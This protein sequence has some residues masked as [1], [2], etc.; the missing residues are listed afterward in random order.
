L[1]GAKF[2]SRPEFFF[3]KTGRGILPKK[4]QPHWWWGTFEE[5]TILKFFRRL[6]F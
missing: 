6:F 5:A 3:R 2:L 4:Q 1:A